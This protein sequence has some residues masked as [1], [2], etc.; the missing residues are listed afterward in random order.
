MHR[1]ENIEVTIQMTD[2]TNDNAKFHGKSSKIIH[3]LALTHLFTHKTAPTERFTLGE[4]F[5][6][7]D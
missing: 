3:V 7:Q 1:L 2:L 5:Y 6:S 4:L